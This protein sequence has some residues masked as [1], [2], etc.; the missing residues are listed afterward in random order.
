MQIEL[1]SFH[2]SGSGTLQL[3]L[4][5]AIR[6]KLLCGQWPVG[7]LLPSSRALAQDLSLSR[8]T[9]NAVLAQL[10]AEGYLQGLPGRG[11]LVTVLTDEYFQPQPGNAAGLTPAAPQGDRPTADVTR[12]PRAN[13]AT[14]GLATSGTQLA[15]TGR[16]S[17]KSG[18]MEPGV[19]DLAAF[20]YRIWQRL[21]QRH[22]DRPA[23]GVAQDKLGYL[24]LRQALTHYLRQSR[25]VQCQPDHI[26]ITAGAQQGLF[27]AAMLVASRGDTVLM[28]SP[29]YSR[30][31]QALQL[32]DLQLSY[33]DA[34]GPDGVKA[35]A[36]AAQPQCKAVF[37][38][39]GHQ[40]PMGG[41]MPLS[42]RLAILQWARQQHCMVVEDDYDS[43]FQFKHRPIASLQGLAAGEGVIF[44]GSFSKTMLPSLRLGYL[45]APPALISKAAS[46][47]QAIHGDIA[48]LGQAALADFIAEG[49]FGRHLRK[50]RKNY[51]QKQQHALLLAQ[52]YLPQWQVHAMHAGL[53][54]VLQCPADQAAHFDETA[55][56]AGLK[57]AGYAPALLSRY[58]F[59][60]EPQRGLVIGIVNLTAAELALGFALIAELTHYQ[61][62]DLNTLS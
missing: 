5:Q 56:L 41:I 26:L 30:L 27:V 9:V 49:H 42:D 11:Y 2:L 48:L 37:L 10:V 60:Q 40:Y 1:G 13:P 14:A 24:P 22:S 36:L 25:Q 29:G 19:P 33:L 54:L 61:Q 38:T 17:A 46:L 31:R 16:S 55:L 8:N 58:Q 20:P 21:L 32:L 53:H 12:Q 23:L 57:Q 51:Q 34:T 35:A 15:V 6:Q 28:E 44:V 62:H 43:E 3:Q 7:A 50:M 45:V 18:L 59:Q 52:Q 4:Y 39:P 47:V